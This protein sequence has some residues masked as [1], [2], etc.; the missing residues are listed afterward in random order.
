MTTA[1]YLRDDLP[2]ASLAPPADVLPESDRGHSLEHIEYHPP[3]PPSVHQG[4]ISAVAL[5]E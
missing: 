2:H 4:I 5:R 1:L 3:E